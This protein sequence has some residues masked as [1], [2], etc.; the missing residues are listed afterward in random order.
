MTTLIVR[1]SN[2]KISSAGSQCPNLSTTAMVAQRGAR[3]CQAQTALSSSELRFASG[4]KTAITR[5]NSR[6]GGVLP[7]PRRAGAQIRAPGPPARPRQPQSPLRSQHEP[8]RNVL[9]CRPHSNRRWIGRVPRWRPAFASSLP[10]ASEPGYAAS[11]LLDVPPMCQNPRR[12][13][14]PHALSRVLSSK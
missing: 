5:S 1:G 12:T 11:R 8:E 6:A 3:A 7:P 10:G 14:R 9:V 13:P 2:S 4:E